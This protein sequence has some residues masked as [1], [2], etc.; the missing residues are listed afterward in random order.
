MPTTSPSVG[1]TQA[2]W[3]NGEGAGLRERFVLPAAFYLGVPA[4]T[5][6][7][8][9]LNHSGLARLLPIEAAV[10]YWLGLTLPLWL[11]LD[12]CTRAARRLLSPWTSR[13]WVAAAAGAVAG[14]IVF[15]P[16]VGAYVRL[17]A[18]FVPDAKLYVVNTPLRA[19]ANLT[20]WI[21]FSGVPLYWLLVLAIFS[22]L[23]DFPDYAGVFGKGHAATVAPARAPAADLAERAAPPFMAL[24]PPRSAGRIL[25]L[26]A[27]DHYVRVHTERG[28]ALI[29]YR[30]SEA[31]AEMRGV[32]GVQVHRSYWVATSEIEAVAPSGKGV[33]VRLKNGLC[34]PVSRSNL[35]VL[36]AEGLL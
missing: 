10:P 1:G 5:A 2:S 15:S 7:L 23:F 16:Y 13:A 31:V 33:S 32:P 18:G 27:E 35:G 4:F 25:A 9:G 30:F 29:R 36:R 28:S 8:F 26:Q 6:L 14:T 34:G 17:V 24:V 3:L 12:L 19:G 22:R 20:Q 21:A 11:L